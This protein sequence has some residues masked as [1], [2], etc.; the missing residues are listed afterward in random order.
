MRYTGEQLI[1]LRERWQRP[2]L[3]PGS[4]EPQET[5][6]DGCRTFRELLSLRM[7][8]ISALAECRLPDVD[9]TTKPEVLRTA[10]RAVWAEQ[11][12]TL[13]ME[14]MAELKGHGLDEVIPIEAPR[15]EIRDSCDL[16]GADLRRAVLTGAF[17]E[18]AH[19]EGAD[20]TRARFDGTRCFETYFEDAVCDQVSFVGAECHFAV[21]RGA[22]CDHASFVRAD[23]TMVRFDQAHLRHAC[24]EASICFAAV[25]DGA[26]LDKA[27]IASMSINHLTRFGRPGELGEAELARPSSA[28]KRGEGDDWYIVEL[29]PAWLRAADINSRIRLLLK[30]HGY[31]LEADEYQYLEMVCRRHVLH[32]NKVS[33]YFEWF[34]KDLM[35]GYG[36]KWKRP[37]ISVLIIILVWAFGFALHFRLNALHG[38]FTSIGYGLYYSVISFTTLGFGNAPDLDGVWPK[39]LLCSEA[40]LGTV[41]MPLFLLA[42]A[43]KILQD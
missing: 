24:F 22:F 27:S 13:F 14:L 4:G 39:V 5:D 23:C 10:L 11:C 1:L 16:R 38:L 6:V 9:G 42:Y 34:F 8:R 12:D 15:Y 17:L 31:F 2:L 19:F 18:N 3:S 41:L 40:L 28:K 30:S 21:F 33:E 36:L 20:L 35:F 37:F 7:A 26:F 32:Q 43:R 25:F 29:F